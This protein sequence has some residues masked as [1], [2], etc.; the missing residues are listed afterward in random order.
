MVQTSRDGSLGA[1]VSFDFDLPVKRQKLTCFIRRFESDAADGGSDNFSRGGQYVTVAQE[2]KTI[3]ACL[4]AY[5]IGY[6]SGTLALGQAHKNIAQTD[7]EGRISREI[8]ELSR[9]TNQ[10]AEPEFGEKLLHLAGEGGDRAGAVFLAGRQGCN[11]DI[12]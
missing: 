3:F 10:Q 4:L 6:N 12:V 9:N 5:V 1:G 11:D 7:I 2:L 8:G